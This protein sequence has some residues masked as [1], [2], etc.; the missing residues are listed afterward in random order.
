MKR[1]ILNYLILPR[2]VSA[3]EDQ[4]LTRMNRVGLWFFALHV[5]IFVLLATLNDTGPMMAA[6]LTS[7]VLLGPIIASQLIESKR[8]MSIV[9]GITAM[10]MGGLLV[11]FGQGPVQIEMH[12]YFFVLLALLAVYAN[13]LVIL[14]AAVTVSLHHA[15]L[16]WFLPASVFNYDAPVWV[17][18]VHAL[19]V[20][21]ESVAACFIARSFFDNVVQL[22][23]KVAQ[24]TDELKSRNQDMRQLLNAVNQ[25]FLT[26]DPQGAMSEER[27]AAVD[28]WLGS[29]QPGTTLCELLHPIDKKFA[30]W[31]ELGLDDVFNSIMPVEVTID[32]LPKRITTEDRIMAFE[33]NAVESEGEVTALA[34]IINDITA[35]VAREKLEAENREMMAMIAR[36]ADD[37]P[38]L[39]EFFQEADSLVEQLRHQPQEDL[40][41]V[42]RLVHTLKG[43]CAIFGLTR[44]AEVCHDIEEWIAESNAMPGRH[45]WTRL[46]DSWDSTCDRLTQ[47][48]SDQ[49]QGIDITDAEYHEMLMAILKNAPKN[50][51]VTRMAGWNLEPTSARMARVAEQAQSLAKRLGKGQI[52][53]KMLGGELRT[54]PR[55]WAEFWAAFIHVVRNAVDHGLEDETERTKLG[56]KAQGTLTLTTMVN[57]DQYI[58]ELTDDGRG[59]DWDRIAEIAYERGLPHASR[60][61][62]TEAIFADSFS[63]KKEVTSTSGRG[64]GLAA[65]QEACERHHG[66][67]R[68]ES[69]PNVGTT[70][71]FVFPVDQM[72]PSTFSLLEDYGIKGIER[73]LQGQETCL[74]SSE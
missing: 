59:I 31:L 41:L 35:D 5:P 4:Y 20:I 48:V 73:T 38:G 60:E 62:L 68:V 21:L 22:E 64:V 66:T 30:G 45:E 50:S 49:S 32:Q 10:L 61:E 23:K 71:Q 24:R 13:P 39:I 3:F 54:D 55:H 51:V 52:D 36:L 72:A 47:L 42:K 33:Y 28:Q 57:D 2:E 67:I 1:A 16:W 53:V 15:L 58:I 26:V 14:A 27:S 44:I 12:F 63:T 65:I 46:F 9:L 40:E 56:K 70:F 37:K 25:G 8:I 6:I 19:F 17:V 74:V 29:P 18:A 43:N 11:H 7:T 69:D 34:V